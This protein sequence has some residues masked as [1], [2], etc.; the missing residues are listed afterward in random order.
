MIKCTHNFSSAV[1]TVT[2]ATDIHTYYSL[3]WQARRNLNARRSFPGHIQAPAFEFN[4]TSDSSSGIPKSCLVD[5]V[6]FSLALSQPENQPSRPMCFKRAISEAWATP[7]GRPRVNII[8]SPVTN[9][10]GN[11]DT[12]EIFEPCF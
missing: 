4:V 10:T 11:V 1:L 6:Y 8:A 3:F 2:T 12:L 7:S 5:A 9:C